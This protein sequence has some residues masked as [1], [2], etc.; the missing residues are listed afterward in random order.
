MKKVILLIFYLPG[1]IQAQSE[2]RGYIGN[3]VFQANQ[4][5]ATF[6]PQGGK[7]SDYD[8]GFFKA[9]Y[10]SD[11]S[12]STIFASAP[13]IGGY[14]QSELKVAGTT[15]GFSHQDYYTGPLGPGA[16][17]YPELCGYFEDIWAV[18]RTEIEAHIL[19]A[20]D[21]TV[22]DH[23][24]AV[25]G[26]PAQGNLYFSQFN[27]FE[28]PADHNGGWADFNDLN[29]NNLYEPQS[30]EYPLI[31]LKGKPYIP[32]QI[33]WMVFNDQGLHEES[34]GN[35]LGVE[36][37][38]TVYGFNC[39]NSSVLNSTLF[40]NYKILNQ[41]V[42]NLDS[43]YF[44][45]WTDYDLGCSE[46]DYVGCDS[47][48]YTEFVYNDVVDGDGGYCS[49][50]ARTYGDYP[51]VQ[52]M[53]YLS[54]PMHSFL[55]DGLHPAN[56]DESP[57]SPEEFYSL[58]N[59]HWSDGTPI[60]PDSSGYNPGFQGGSTHFLYPGDPRDPLQWS[61]Y[62][63]SI[64]FG[65]PRTVSSVYLDSLRPKESVVVETAYMFHQ[66]SS[67]DHLEQVGFMYS[68]LDS[69]FK[70]ISDSTLSCVRSPACIGRDCVWPG[71]FYHNGIADHYDIL[72]WGV[73]KDSLG[74]KRN[75]R[76]N[77][78]GHSADP[79]TLT[80]PGDLNAKHGDGNGNGIVNEED[81]DRN[82]R[83]YLYTNPYYE[84]QELFPVGPEIV[85]SSRPMAPNG[86]IKDILIMAGIDF[87]Q[88][89]GLAYEID[90]DT[91][92]YTMDPY[93]RIP[94]C[95]D[96]PDILCLHHEGYLPVDPYFEVS[97][98]YGFVKT[99]HQEIHIEQG[100]TF[101]RVF[102]GL[103]LKEGV[104]PA[105]IPDTVVIRLKNLIAIDA[106]GNDLQ[107]G[108]APLLVPKGEIVG[109]ND[110]SKYATTIYPNPADKFIYMDAGI[111]SEVQILSIH[112]QIL[113][114]L[115]VNDITKPIDVSGLTPGVY[116][117]RFQNSGRVVKF[118]KQ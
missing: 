15:F 107:I 56:H 81:I 34:N 21:G 72:Y 60:I 78:D 31:R 54:H 111:D 92:I 47:L 105:D 17:T 30:G 10:T 91:S 38:L 102:K 52:S 39:E 70:W 76:I 11:L 86:Q 48:R 33:F 59:G 80:L 113:R 22:D 6:S 37:Q 117:L 112:G 50:G 87:D 46:D 23:I 98:R 18:T 8:Y 1:L 110:P 85:L 62:Q 20:S 53:T 118:L 100:F 41:G 3:E 13:W 5:G 45:M 116:F 9:P 24:P 101:E 83:H 94:I 82:I 12:A 49:S 93:L 2:C 43:V 104:S 114:Q 73:M 28:L 67:L 95:P 96:Y 19:D 63:E 77:W 35:P 44:G 29:G 55:A 90:F 115:E 99:D 108:A 69:L 66:D 103:V 68:N 71:D 25:F 58:L 27:S 14:S 16:T 89:L 74:H 79:W 109:L 51:P 88:V 4:I 75:G 65:D 57:D 84:P 97:P 26:W 36:M 61:W 7:F 32:E 64:H 42:A 40:N 106:D